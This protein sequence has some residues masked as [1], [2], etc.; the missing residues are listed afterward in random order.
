VKPA[1]SL[2]AVKGGAAAARRPASSFNFIRTPL[3]LA[4]RSGRR[5]F[6]GM[7]SNDPTPSGESRDDTQASLETRMLELEERVRQLE[8][9]MAALGRMEGAL[10]KVED[11]VAGLFRPD[12]TQSAE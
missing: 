6:S 8:K 10:G 1:D 5:H 2:W 9:E 3:R 4:S 7:D 12:S 11:A